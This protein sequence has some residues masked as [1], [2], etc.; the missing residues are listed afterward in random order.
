VTAPSPLDPTSVVVVPLRPGPLGR[1]DEDRSPDEVDAVLDELFG[2][3]DDRGPGAADAVL[4][5]GGALVLLVGLLASWPAIV[6]A[7]GAAALALGAILPVRSVWRRLRAGRRDS[8]L[9][10]RLA[11]GVALRVDDAGVAA[12]VEWHDKL[13]VDAGALDAVDR[14][15]VGSIAHA[16]VYE[17]ATLLGGRRP[18]GDEVTYVAERTRALRDLDAALGTGNRSADSSARLAARAEVE[19]SGGSSVTDARA[20]TEELR[21]DRH[22]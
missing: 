20:L 12:L 8:T 4:A 2:E 5:G 17:V 1:I 9:D 7:A 10:R 11:E 19:A 15:R 18:G 14:L 6:I 21:D 13:L 16:A 3:P 22:R